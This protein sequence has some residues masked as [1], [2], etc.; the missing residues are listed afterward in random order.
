ML[1]KHQAHVTTVTLNRPH[2]LNALDATMSWRLYDALREA[3][4]E[5]STGAIVLTGPAAPSGRRQDRQHGRR[6]TNGLGP[7]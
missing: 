2:I 4:A 3:D 1:V 5:P 6:P 7:A